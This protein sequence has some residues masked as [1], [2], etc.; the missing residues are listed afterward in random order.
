MPSNNLE[1]KNRMKHMLHPPVDHE[2]EKW[3]QSHKAREHEWNATKHN[4][5]N[6]INDY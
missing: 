6:V 2:Q 1:K 5:E 4:K 3:T